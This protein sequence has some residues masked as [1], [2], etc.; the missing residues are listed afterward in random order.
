[1]NQ[2]A[3]L[4]SIELLLSPATINYELPDGG[5]KQVDAATTP[6]IQAAFNN[7]YARANK[8]EK[9]VAVFYFCGHGLESDVTLL[10]L[11]DFGSNPNNLWDHAR[12]Y[13]CQ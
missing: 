8:S 13:A 7:W 2:Q 6:N 9:N 11:E 5:F 12:D 3:P 4:G 10:L 1:M